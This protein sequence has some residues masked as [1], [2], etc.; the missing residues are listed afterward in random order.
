[1]IE[2][3]R[4]KNSI[5]WTFRNSK[6]RRTS[7]DCYSDQMRRTFDPFRLLV[8]SMAGWLGQQQRDGRHAGDHHC[9]EIFEEQID[10]WYRV[11]SAWLVDRTFDTFNRWFECCFHSVLVDLCDDPL[12]REA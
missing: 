9:R 3:V 11:P 8:I 5:S 2:V 6:V 1:M 7:A 4:S 10:G 12:M